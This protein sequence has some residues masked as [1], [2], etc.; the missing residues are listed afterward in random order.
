M[1]HYP[2]K[3]HCLISF[4]FFA[5]TLSLSTRKKNLFLLFIFI[6]CTCLGIIFDDIHSF[7][8]F[9][10]YMIK[11]RWFYDVNV[12][13]VVV[14]DV[15]IIG[16]QFMGDT[17]IYVKE[18]FFYSHRIY[19]SLFFLISL[20]FPKRIRSFFCCCCRYC[21]LQTLIVFACVC[22]SRLFPFSTS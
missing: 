3:C 9:L 22:V 17:L 2:E 13:A 20:F 14:V 15:G 10:S 7:I 4:Y 11:I 16:R 12:V 8:H 18:F 21:C 5:S 1:F 19:D 6:T